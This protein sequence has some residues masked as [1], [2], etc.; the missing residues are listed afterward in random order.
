MPPEL[1]EYLRSIG[2]LS[3]DGEKRLARSVPC[4]S[5][6]QLTLVGTTSEPCSFT[7][8]CELLPLD[9]VG[10]V[11]ALMAS[12]MTYDARW[13]RARLG[14]QLDARDSFRIR[15]HPAAS[16]DELSGGDLTTVLAEHRCGAP[17][18]TSSPAVRRQMAAH[19]RRAADPWNTEGPA[20]F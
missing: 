17:A 10:E 12:R 9:A 3:P 2:T 13:Q 5:C 8:R 1:V 6:G 18:L 20:P 14:Y 11:V 7:A 19:L 4:Q 16:P 15:G